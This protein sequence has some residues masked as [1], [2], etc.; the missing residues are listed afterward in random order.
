MIEQQFIENL[1]KEG[2]ELT[3]TMIQQFRTYTSLLQEWNEKI[4]LT[5]LNETSEIYEKHFYDS[6][7]I[8]RLVYFEGEMCDVGSGAGFPGIPCKIVFPELALTIVEPIKKRCKFL[9]ILCKELQINV[10]IVNGRAE[11]ITKEY[12]IVTARAVANLRILAELCI[13]L[14][15]KDGYFIAMKGSQGLI[16]KREAQKATTFLGCEQINEDAIK[17]PDEAT[18]INLLYKKVRNTPVGYP[19]MYAKI[20]KNPL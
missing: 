15:K 20:K 18:R 10:N 9:E 4:N 2:I 19:R 16:E 12:D 17:L 6:L 13:P 1:Q 14:V 8:K 3:K 5:S 7:L 11:E